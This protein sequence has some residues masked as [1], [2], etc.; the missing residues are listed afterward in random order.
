[1]YFQYKF[2]KK[3]THLPLHRC[4]ALVIRS[5]TPADSAVT[6]YLHDV[7]LQHPV[8]HTAQT[9][10]PLTSH[11]GIRQLQMERYIMCQST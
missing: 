3:P 1:M 2:V 6:V 10:M 4:T 8:N 7:R 5:S 9:T 11:L